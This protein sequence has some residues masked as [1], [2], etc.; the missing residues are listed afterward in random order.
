MNFQPMVN[1]IQHLLGDFPR[2]K[3][4]G[5]GIALPLRIVEVLSSF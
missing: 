4:G 5:V 3:M 1:V 2:K